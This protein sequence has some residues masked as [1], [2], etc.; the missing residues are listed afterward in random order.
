MLEYL[1]S[2]IMILVLWWLWSILQSWWR[3]DSGEMD[4]STLALLTSTPGVE[5]E[6]KAMVNAMNSAPLVQDEAKS[7]ALFKEIYRKGHLQLRALVNDPG[8]LL[9]V[10]RHLTTGDGALGT[11]FTVS[12]NL[13]AGSVAA[14]GSNEQREELFS[15]QKDG[16][17]G[18]FA[19]TEKGAGVM[20]GAA[21]ETTAHYDTKTQEFIIDSPTPSASK[22]WI[23]QGLYAER[24]VILANLIIDGDNK[25]C[26]L[27]WARIATSNKGALAGCVPGVHVE[28]MPPKAALRGLDNANIT[29][30]KFRVPRTALLNRFSDVAADGSYTQN[31]PEGV[32]RMLEL[33]ISRLLTGR[34]CLSESM[35]AVAQDR[36]RHAWKYC[37]QREL[38]RGKKPQGKMM[39][40]M[41]LIRRAFRDYARSMAVI[42]RFM[43][44]TREDVITSVTNDCFSAS[45]VE[46]TCMCKFMGTSFAVDTLSALRKWLGARAL[47]EEANMGAETYIGYATAAA[48][49]DNTIMELKVVGDMFRGRTPRLPFQLMRRIVHNAQGRRA[50]GIFV[51]RVAR[52]MLLQKRALKAGQLLRDIA[53]AR[54]HMRV[55]DVWLQTP[56]IQHRDAF[57]ESYGRIAMHFPVPIQV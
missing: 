33:L 31:L 22:T 35:G 51:S 37:E 56:D 48:E 44:H 47:Q 18:C 45:T 26:H 54:A 4:D 8:R 27:F 34:I 16:E 9:R 7:A 29:F 50:I 49:G 23:S 10:S 32:P 6:V 15:T 28:S 25:G 52:A 13:Y 30:S 38:W 17:L 46:A 14:L 39:S 43:A 3:V 21:A 11:R 57:L 53:W 24:A 2:I 55:I 5:R 41:P 1:S 20:S 40:E 42:Q 12:Y 19:F 36:L